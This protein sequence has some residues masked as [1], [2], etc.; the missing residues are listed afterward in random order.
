MIFVAA[1]CG[2]AKRGTTGDDQGTV[3]APPAG[4]VPT[5]EV[6]NDGIDNDCDGKVDC[7][8][9]DCSG[10][11]GCPVCGMVNDPEATP[12]AL[13]DGVTSGNGCSVDADCAGTPATPNCII[14][15]DSGGGTLKECHA[16]YISTLDFIGFPAG[17]TLTDPSKLLNVCVTMEHSY[18]HDLQI[19]LLTPPDMAGTRRLLALNKFVGQVGPEI[20]LGDAND[21][22][23]AANPVAGVGYKYC[24]T[25]A[26]TTDMDTA[27][28]ASTSSPKKLPAGDY[29]PSGAFSTLATA[30]LNG[31]WQM[32]ITDLFPI[33]N[34][35]LFGWSIAFDPSLV[36]DCNGPII[37]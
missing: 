17:A 27:G 1:A 33:D 3:D 28:A 21:A 37:Q 12:L 26:A 20:Y 4:C 7:G 2:P 11:D 24:W 15:Q 18:L 16:S 13:P 8:D 22:D 14:F 36:A 23:T 30:E 19:E 9:I 35:F 6:C 10:I 5:A 31:M 29:K 34:G 25:A 32:R